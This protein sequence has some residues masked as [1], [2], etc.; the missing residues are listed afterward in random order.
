[1]K[2]LRQYLNQ[3]KLLLLH[4]YLM[5]ELQDLLSFKNSMKQRQSVP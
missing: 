4:L 2:E 5:L 3:H 1:M